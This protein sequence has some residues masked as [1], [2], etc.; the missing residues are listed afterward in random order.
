MCG[1]EEWVWLYQAQKNLERSEQSQFIAVRML[2]RHR[3]RLLLYAATL[4]CYAPTVCCYAIAYAAA[5]LHTVCSYAKPEG[6]NLFG[7]E[8]QGLSTLIQGVL[9]MDDLLAQPHVRPEE[10]MRK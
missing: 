6:R 9:D 2:L 4:V 10:A 1:T 7:A 5:H 3:T 8:L